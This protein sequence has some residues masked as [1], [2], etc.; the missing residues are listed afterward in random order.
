MKGW[1]MLATLQR[2]GVVP[3]FSRPRVSDDNPH[4]EALCR[5]LKYL[6]EYP[7]RPFATVEQARQWV[8]RF[9]AWYNGEHLHSSNSLRHARRPP[10]RSRRRAARRPPRPPP[11]GPVAGRPELDGSDPQL[12]AHRPCDPQPPHARGSGTHEDSTESTGSCVYINRL[13][14]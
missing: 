14:V 4:A 10:P 6:P 13:L 2:L 3:S 9:V 12:D 1:T 5:T 11:S 8:E 7:R